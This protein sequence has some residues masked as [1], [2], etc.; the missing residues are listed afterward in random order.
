MM[1]RRGLGVT[2]PEMRAAAA[3]FFLG[4][5]SSASA[6]D[7]GEIALIPDVGGQIQQSIAFASRYLER[8]ACAFY[9]THNDRYDAIFVYTTV[10]L[11][12]LTRTQQGWATRSA[13]M[14]IGRDIYFDTTS[15]FCSTRLRHAVKMGD[16]GSYSDNPDDIYNGIFGFTL[17]GIELMGHEF[18]HQWM[19]AVTFE[20]SDG[21]RHCTIRG[22]NPPTEPPINSFCDG[23]RN[24]DFNPHWSYYM[25]T[26]SVMYGNTIEDL[27]GGQ[28]RVSNP[29]TKFSELDQYLMGLRA[30]AEVAPMFY[31]GMGTPDATSTAF[32]I[33]RG[34]TEIISGDREDV[35][36]EDIIRAE[37]PRV[38][39][40]D[41]CHW[42]AAFLLV[43]PEN[44]P[45]TAQEIARVD[46]YRRRWEEFYAAA[47]DQ[48]G[49][50]DTTLA[51]T[52]AG[53]VTCAS[54]EPPEPADAGVGLL[55]AAGPGA[56]DAGEV[57][58][59]DSGVVE[60]ADAGEVIGADAGI[61]EET[62]AGGML[63]PT[64]VDDPGSGRTDETK[65]LVVDD[66]AC[67]A[68]HREAAPVVWWLFFAAAGVFLRR[69]N[70]A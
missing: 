44:S 10:N 1:S 17:S 32:P 52:G 65:T 24:A 18:G 49:S 13:A 64:P 38:P 55:D 39:A 16:V 53:T 60:A 48:R 45:P 68:A 40:T 15:D 6:Q 36:I 59:V 69:R 19:S 8:A 66:C 5:A 7:V 4:L 21:I 22:F 23:Y 27:G 50:F 33:E 41:I 51:G 25:N 70:T 26:A 46:T 9:Q 2:F 43:H 29:A 57:I 62:D 37:G 28:F 11:N 58:I 56:P 47:T 30:P 67:N 35:T 61:V 63:F 31:V 54:T 3:I 34:Q 42:K 14:G 12:M 20:R